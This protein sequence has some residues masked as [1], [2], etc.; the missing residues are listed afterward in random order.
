MD[1]KIYSRNRIRLPKIIIQNN[2]N[3]N[4]NT[5][6]VL[7]ITAILVIAISVAGFSL[8]GIQ[9]IIEKNCKSMAKS[10]ATKVSNIKATEVMAKYE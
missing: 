10:V 7:K 6:K 4:K 1:D 2:R 3:P 9:P 5:S 8:K